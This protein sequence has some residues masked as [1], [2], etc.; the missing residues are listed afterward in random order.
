[1]IKNLVF[2]YGSTDTK[3]SI[4]SLIKNEE[5]IVYLNYVDEW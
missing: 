4:S 2:S 3:Y 5:E 1:L